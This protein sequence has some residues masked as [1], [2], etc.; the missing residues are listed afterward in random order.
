MQVFETPFAVFRIRQ[1][2][3]A[4]APH[5]VGGSLGWHDFLASTARL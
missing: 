2:A 5:F 3:L 1:I 4:L